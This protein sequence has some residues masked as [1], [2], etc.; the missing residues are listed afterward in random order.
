MMARG[1]F[2]AS[3]RRA[4]HLRT[5]WA[6]AR[7]PDLVARLEALRKAAVHNERGGS[8]LLSYSLQVADASIVA[9]AKASAAAAAKAMAGASAA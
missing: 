9:R 2:R 5:R 6:Q 8:L 7:C 1:C 4:D 3:A